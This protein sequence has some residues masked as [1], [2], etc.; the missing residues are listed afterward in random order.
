ME[1]LPVQCADSLRVQAYFDGETDAIAAAAI[2]QHLQQCAEC[3]ALLGQLNAARTAMREQLPHERIPEPSRAR[4]LRALGREGAVDRDSSPQERGTRRPFWLGTLTGLGSAACAAAVGWWLLMPTLQRAQPDELVSAHIRSMVGS[5]AID[6]VSTDRHTVKP[7][8]GAHG[9]VSPVV[10]DF[11]AAG[12]ALLG[13]RLDYIDH[14]RASVSVYQH[15]AHTVD[16][17]SW[18]A[19]GTRQRDATREGYHMHFWRL[20]DIEYCA[21]SDTGWDELTAPEQLLRSEEARESAAIP[22]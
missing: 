18:A 21:V 17:F 15:G 1:Q 3:R 2:E 12:Y 16:V 19:D 6:V 7:W 5:H 14:R 4:L 10:A 11:S 20:E 8:F 22:P 13:G 9:D